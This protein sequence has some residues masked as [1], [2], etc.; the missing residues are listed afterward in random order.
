MTKDKRLF[1][2]FLSTVLVMAIAVI[3]LIL[4]LPKLDYNVKQETPKMDGYASLLDGIYAKNLDRMKEAA[5]SFFTTDRVAMYEGNQMSLSSMYS[6]K[7]LVP[8]KDKN[9]SSCD[10]TE[11]YVLLTK[12]NNEYVLKTNLKCGYEESY[13]LTHIGCYPYCTGKQEEKKVVVSTGPT[14]TNNNNN[15]NGGGGTTPPPVTTK[16]LYEHKK[17]AVYSPWYR[18][19]VTGEGIQT[20]RQSMCDYI[21]LRYNTYQTATYV[22]SET[23][24]KYKDKYNKYQYTYSYRLGDIP[25]NA[26]RVVINGDRRFNNTDYYSFAGGSWTIHEE[27]GSRYMKAFGVDQFNP[28]SLGSYNF[29]YKLSKPYKS[30]GVYYVD[31]TITIKNINDMR[32][33]PIYSA[34]SNDRYYIVPLAFYLEYQD[35]NNITTD[36]CENWA[37]YAPAAIENSSHSEWYYRYLISPE[38]FIWTENKTEPGYTA[39]G[40]TKTS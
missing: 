34:S 24:N 27:G 18:G 35:R 3:L 29:D 20:E 2:D 17:D 26:T 4:I 23:L 7:L 32:A 8:F 31:V 5:I 1:Y 9:G 30:N 28:N 19:Y 12:E 38:Q 33:T 15:N 10:T 13:T 36:S 25:Y 37:G 22:S 21:K 6:Q 40:K 14:W 11:S 16:T 39:T